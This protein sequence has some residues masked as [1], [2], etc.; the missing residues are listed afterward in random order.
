MSGQVG[1][2]QRDDRLRRRARP[3]SSAW[4]SARLAGEQRLALEQ[5]AQ[6]VEV[7]GRLAR[8]RLVEAVAARDRGV[9]LLARVV[10]LEHD[11]DLADL[12]QPAH[13]GAASAA[14]R[15]AKFGAH[16]GV[17]SR[18]RTATS[19]S[20]VTTQEPTKPSVVIGSSSSGS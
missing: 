5:L 17:G 12:R 8:E 7:A 1:H 6:R 11:G 4:H 3:P 19:P 9:D 20:S 13:G 18:R 10:V 14:I 16:C 15:N 2:A